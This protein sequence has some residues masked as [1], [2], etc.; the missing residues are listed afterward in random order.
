MI[1]LKFHLFLLFLIFLIFS[2]IALMYYFFLEPEEGDCVAPEGFFVVVIVAAIS[3]LFLF[4]F[5][6]L[7][8]DVKDAYLI[9]TELIL[10]IITCFPFFTLWGVAFLLRWKGVLFSDFFLN[11]SFFSL[12]VTAIV[13]PLLGTY[14]FES[15]QKGRVRGSALLEVELVNGDELSAIMGNKILYDNFEKFCTS[16]W[17]VE[18]LLFHKAV[19]EYRRA[20]EDELPTKAINIHDRFI[21]VDSPFEVNLEMK[22]REAISEM[23]EGQQFTKELFDEADHHIV[24]LLKVSVLPL[25][26]ASRDAKR[27]RKKSGF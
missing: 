26:R 9:K 19:E 15:I 21:Q 25:W 20:S 14:Y 24:G 16:C 1:S 12:M 13:L 23:I 22:T 5:C 3:F 6:F 17:C 10:S 27:A 8:W 11:L 7:L 2:F 18:N 4:L